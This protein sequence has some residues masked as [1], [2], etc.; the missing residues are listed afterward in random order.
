MLDSTRSISI[1]IKLQTFSK[2]P[3][4][5]HLVDDIFHPMANITYISMVS[6]CVIGMSH[7]TSYNT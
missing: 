1:F 7:I 5:R 4:E 3:P 2:I 6:L